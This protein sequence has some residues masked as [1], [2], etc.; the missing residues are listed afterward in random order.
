MPIVNG[1]YYM[2]G[3]YGQSLE[4]AKIADAFPGLA[5]QTGSGDSLADRLVD[6]LTTPRSATAPPPAPAPPGMPPE[7]YDYMKI[8]VLLKSLDE[9]IFCGFDADRARSTGTLGRQRAD[10]EVAVEVIADPWVPD[11]FRVGGELGIFVIQ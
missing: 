5:D 8:N 9:E 11:F 2:N 1:N 3:D 10:L 4:H 6:H 7:A